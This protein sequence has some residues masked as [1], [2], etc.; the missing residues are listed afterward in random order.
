MSGVLRV[1]RHT[2]RGV[3]CA[4]EP[5]PKAAIATRSSVQ[6][7]PPK[8]QAANDAMG[9]GRRPPARR[10]G[11][12]DLARPGEPTA[13]SLGARPEWEAPPPPL[14][15]GLEKNCVPLVFFLFP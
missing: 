9:G 10:A 7:G 6:A 12:P 3:R 11:R 8:V 14:T 4:S 1:L 13:S 2:G 5:R 15:Q